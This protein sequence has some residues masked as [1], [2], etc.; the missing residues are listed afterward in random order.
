MHL[1]HARVELS[2]QH[3]DPEDFPETCMRREFWVLPFSMH[4]YVFEEFIL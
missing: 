4:H 1:K 2:I 3:A